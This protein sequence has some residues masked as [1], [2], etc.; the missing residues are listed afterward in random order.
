MEINLLVAIQLES[1]VLFCLS[2]DRI[3]AIAGIGSFLTVE[4]RKIQQ[5]SVRAIAINL[6][7][8]KSVLYFGLKLFH[9]PPI[10]A[11]RR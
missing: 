4:Q 8:V 10:G 9:Q 5:L 6:S 7:V 11:K 2:R 3:S 1:A